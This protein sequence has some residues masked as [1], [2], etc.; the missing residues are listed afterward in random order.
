VLIWAVWNMAR[1][2]QDEKKVESSALGPRVQGKVIRTKRA[3]RDSLR[4]LALR[5]KVSGHIP[6]QLA[7]RSSRRERHGKL[8]ECSEVGAEGREDINQYPIGAKVIIRYNRSK[9]KE[10]VLYCMGEVGPHDSSGSNV[11]PPHSVTLE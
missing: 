11:E 2:G 5:G 3:R 7:P 4:A 6:N 9:P 8:E 1:C 10:S